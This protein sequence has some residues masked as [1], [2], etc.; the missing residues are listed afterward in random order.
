[1]EI[2]IKTTSTKI[3][4]IPDG[5]FLHHLSTYYRINKDG[6]VTEVVDYPFQHIESLDIYPR[7]QRRTFT[8]SFSYFSEKQIDQITIISEDEFNNAL[9]RVFN[10]LISE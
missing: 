5:K 8:S 6:T 2:Q 1:M 9:H 4:K 7:I 3:V 10:L